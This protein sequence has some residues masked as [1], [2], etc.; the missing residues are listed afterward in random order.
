[1]QPTLIDYV[2]TPGN[3]IIFTVGP[4][5]CRPSHT[6]TFA[7][8][9]SSS[10]TSCY[11]ALQHWNGERVEIASAGSFFKINYRMQTDIQRNSH[12]NN[13]IPSGLDLR[14]HMS[15]LLPHLWKLIF[16]APA[17]LIVRDP[18]TPLMTITFPTRAFLGCTSLPFAG[19]KIRIQSSLVYFPIY[20]M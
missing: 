13:Q 7:I 2:L 16:H 6:S 17:S 1:M 19:N 10:M 20:L 4:F 3:S 8:S 11:R 18:G 5:E 12:Q 14:D 9:G 15:T